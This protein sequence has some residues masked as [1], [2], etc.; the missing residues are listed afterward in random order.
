VRTGAKVQNWSEGGT[1]SAVALRPMLTFART[2]GV[3]VEAILAE[4]GMPPSALDEYDR[5]IPEASRCRAWIEA[6]AGARDPSFGLHVA[7]HARIGAY[8]VLDHSLY[9]S[10]TL[11]EALD[12][13]VRFHRVLCDAWAIHSEISAGIARVRRT[14][15]TPPHEVESAFAFLVLRARELT[16]LPLAPHEVRFAHAA[17]SD[18]SSHAALFRAPVRFGCAASELVF[19]ANDL[20]LPVKFANPGVLGVLD[21]YMTDLLARLPKGPSF[22][23]RVRDVITRTLRGGRPTLRSTARAL[24]A[25]PRTVQRRLGDHGTSHTEIVHAVRRELAER[26]VAEG[27]MSITEIAFLLGFTDVSGFRRLY[28]RWTGVAPS[29]GRPDGSL[30]R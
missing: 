24:H 23:E 6:A 9:F 26:L 10:T 14:E 29:R 7:E 19:A 25:S 4:I 11:D 21:R 13:I 2:R 30:S 17:P 22:V 27:R 12:R 3:D 1:A 8:D 28:K 20:T 16:G 15:Q 5:R 18:T